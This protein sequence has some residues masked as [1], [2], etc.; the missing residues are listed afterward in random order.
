MNT[1]TRLGVV[2]LTSCAALVG[3]GGIATATPAVEPLRPAAAPSVA[4][5]AAQTVKLLKEVDRR[6]WRTREARTAAVRAALIQAKKTCAPAPYEVRAEAV[7]GRDP[8]SGTLR[9]SCRDGFELSPTNPPGAYWISFGALTPESQASVTRTART[10]RSYEIDYTIQLSTPP[11]G[12][13]YLKGTC[14]PAAD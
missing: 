13:L 5:V 10:T 6:T 3:A 1:F 9:I 7:Q 11:G 4:C 12:G 8:V 2:A 14:V